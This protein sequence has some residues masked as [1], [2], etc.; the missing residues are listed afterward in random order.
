MG[1]NHNVDEWAGNGLAKPTKYL[2]IKFKPNSEKQSKDPG[3]NLTRG[4]F[5]N[6]GYSYLHHLYV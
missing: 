2:K 1:L 3:S 6:H 4:T 5:S